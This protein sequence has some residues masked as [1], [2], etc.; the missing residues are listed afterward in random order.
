MY[1]Y[2]QYTV[3]LLV[4]CIILYR[5]LA[6]NKLTEY[7]NVSSA[8][9]LEEVWVIYIHTYI[10]IAQNSYVFEVGLYSLLKTVNDSPMYS[11]S[12]LSNWAVFDHMLKWVREWLIIRRWSSLWALY[13]FAL[14]T[15]QFLLHSQ[16]NMR[17][18][19]LPM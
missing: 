8:V 15:V 17:K 14:M 16:S 1:V 3:L 19:D 13:N 10:I 12:F 18:H 7:P 9:N 5:S 4:V 2:V 11:K 6:N